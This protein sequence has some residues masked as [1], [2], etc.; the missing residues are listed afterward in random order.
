MLSDEVE[1]RRRIVRQGKFGA[2]Q[3]GGFRFDPLQS[4][5]RENLTFHT[6]TLSASRSPY[7][8]LRSF[9]QEVLQTLPTVNLDE[10]TVNAPDRRTDALEGRFKF[11]AIEF[12]R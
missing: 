5:T 11:V 6:I 3:Q 10:I 2:A 7:Q 9:Y 8:Q 4:V 1:C 12:N